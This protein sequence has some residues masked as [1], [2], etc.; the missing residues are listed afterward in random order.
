MTARCVCGAM[1][2]PVAREKRSSPSGSA[3]SSGWRRPDV[4][5][6]LDVGNTHIVLGLYENEAL[7]ASW[8][9]WTHHSRTSDQWAV[10]IA[11]LLS[12]KGLGLDTVDA[13]IMSSV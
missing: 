1:R 11:G 2:R 7:Q 5:L 9:L 3:K 10:E 13:A 12:L 4:L 8:R 6:V